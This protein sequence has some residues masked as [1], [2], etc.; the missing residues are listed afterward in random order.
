MGRRD[1]EN[2]IAVLP[3]VERIRESLNKVAAKAFAIQRVNIWLSRDGY[4]GRFYCL[5]KSPAQPGFLRLIPC[6]GCFDV[7]FSFWQ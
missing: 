5:D 2:S 1:D 6:K 4:T 7:G 3:V